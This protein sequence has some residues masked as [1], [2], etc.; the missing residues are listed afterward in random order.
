MI[1]RGMQE[2]RADVRGQVAR[3][4]TAPPRAV[5]EPG[6][7]K[8]LGR[9]VHDFLYTSKRDGRASSGAVL[10]AVSGNESN[11][12]REM[13]V[14]FEP[15]AASMSAPPVGYSTSVANAESPLRPSTSAP[16]GAVI[17]ETQGAVISGAMFGQ[18]S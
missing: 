9:T 12:T 5:V 14:D 7:E 3:A 6:Q 18:N 15:E 2:V 11:R 8:E 13:G 4:Q 1:D 16:Q 10:S 17:A